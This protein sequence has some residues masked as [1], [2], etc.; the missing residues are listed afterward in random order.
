MDEPTLWDDLPAPWRA[1]WELA[2]EAYRAGSYPIG[3]VL[4][5]PGGELLARGRNR[6][7]ED[8]APQGQACGSQI[9]HAELNVLLGYRPS[10]PFEIYRCT[11]YTTTEPCPL[12]LGAIYMSG[13]RSF[14]FAARDPVAGS[15]GLLGATPYLAR[16]Q[17]AVGA[18]EDPSLE[19]VVMALHVDYSLRLGG[20]HD[21]VLEAWEAVVPAGVALG[22]RAFADSLL[23]GLAARDAPPVEAYRALREAA[24]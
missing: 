15:A 13:L 17:L 4:V 16:K 24:P 10:D 5:G 1:C 23:A 11:L 18:A 14:R 12:C 3:A 9:A 7:G 21:W 22:R 2:W 20:R 6:T 8:A 19:Q